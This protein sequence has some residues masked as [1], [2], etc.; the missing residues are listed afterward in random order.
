M[1][2]NT[3]KKEVFDPTKVNEDYWWLRSNKNPDGSINDTITIIS[4][5]YCLADFMG[6]SINDVEKECGEKPGYFRNVLSSIEHEWNDNSQPFSKKILPEIPEEVIEKSSKLFYVTVDTLKKTSLSPDFYYYTYGQ[7]TSLNVQEA[8]NEN[9]KLVLF[10]EK[11]I[12][13]CQSYQFNIVS[14][15]DGDPNHFGA[16]YEIADVKNKFYSFKIYK[17]DSGSIAIVICNQVGGSLVFHNKESDIIYPLADRMENVLHAAAV[18]DANCKK[19][20][21]IPHGVF[22]VMDSFLKDTKPKKAISNFKYVKPEEPVTKQQNDTGDMH[23]VFSD[24]KD[25]EEPETKEESK[26]RSVG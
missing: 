10:I 26:G 7:P 25:Q 15:K 18:R 2:T 11:I 1:A 4:N 13:D 14:F 23:E 16:R 24:E 8:N 20:I 21:D 17:D 3:K 19:V 5:I 6:M 9:M 22:D 12:L